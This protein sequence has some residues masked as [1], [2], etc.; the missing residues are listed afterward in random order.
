MTADGS[1]RVRPGIDYATAI[2]QV[3]FNAMPPAAVYR[4]EFDETGRVIPE[5]G[6]R[7]AADSDWLQD[8]HDLA[9]AAGKRIRRFPS[10]DYPGGVYRLVDEN[11]GERR[12]AL[13]LAVLMGRPDVDGLLA[14]MNSVQWNE[15]QAWLRKR[16]PL[17]PVAY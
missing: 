15:W 4:A 1:F 2:A 8:A 7:Y 17:P 3:L 6:L 11:L 14:E 16:L 9:M 5:P 12:L 10:A 13:E